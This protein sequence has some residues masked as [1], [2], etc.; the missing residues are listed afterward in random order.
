L[1]LFVSLFFLCICV[2]FLY[3]NAQ[4]KV[5]EQRTVCG[6]SIEEGSIGAVILLCFSLFVCV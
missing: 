1:L 4:A 3:F 2:R 5:V 6:P